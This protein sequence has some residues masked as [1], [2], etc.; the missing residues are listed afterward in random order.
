MPEKQVFSAADIF[1]M[2]VRMEHH[3][4]AFYKAFASKVQDPEIQEVFRFMI[5][6]ETKH[7]EIF[8]GMKSGLDEHKLPESYQG[9]AGSYLDAFVKDQVFSS[10]EEAEQTARQITDRARAI[11]IALELEKSSILFYSGMKE[12]VRES[13]HGNIDLIIAEERDHIR[14]LSSLKGNPSL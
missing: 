14:R 10:P 8:S 1:D 11:D 13:D 9:E 5:D 2:A 4:L 3:G 7:I 6:Q 12:V